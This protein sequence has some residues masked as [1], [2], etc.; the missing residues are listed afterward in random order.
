M[1]R[2]IQGSFQLIFCLNQCLD[3]HPVKVD[4]LSFD[5]DSTEDL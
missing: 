5:L 1:M 4:L 2:D 3:K